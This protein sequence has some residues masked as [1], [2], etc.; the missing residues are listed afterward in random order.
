MLLQRV[1]GFTL[2]RLW[3]KEKVVTHHGPNA[4]KI[5]VSKKYLAIVAAEELI[6]KVEQAS[7]NVDPHEGEVPLERAAKPSTDGERFWPMQQ[8]FL[9][10]LCAEAGEGTKNL[11]A[12]SDHYEEGNGVD[13]MTQAYGQWVFVCGTAN[14]NGFFAFGASN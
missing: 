14:H 2:F 9:R 8:V 5:A 10:N 6:S 11:Q 3:A 13:P 7:A 4:R 1:V 12:A